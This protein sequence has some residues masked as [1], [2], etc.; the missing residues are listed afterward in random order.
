MLRGRSA[1][2]RMDGDSRAFQPFVA[3]GLFLAPA[4]CERFFDEIEALVQPIAADHAVVREGQMLCTGS[5]G[6][7]HVLPPDRERIDA[8]LAAQF[9]DRGLDGECG[10]RRAISPEGAGRHRVRVDRIARPLL[11]RAAVGGHRGA[12]RRG[13]DLAAVVAV[14]AGVGDGVDLHRRQRAVLFRAQLDRDLHRMPGD[15]RGEL[16]GAGELPL[17]RTAGL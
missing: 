8:Q 17:H 13:E 2:L 16:L 15:G 4:A 10:L 11:V 6:L 14:G 12:E 5:C 1:V 3:V 9:V 7:H